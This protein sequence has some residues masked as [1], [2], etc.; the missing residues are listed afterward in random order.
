MH[1]SIF[2]KN[3][4]FFIYCSTPFKSMLKCTTFSQ[5]SL[6]NKICAMQNSVHVCLKHFVRLSH[7]VLP[8]H[9]DH[10]CKDLDWQ[11]LEAVLVCVCVC[12]LCEFACQHACLM[13][14][15]SGVVW[16]WALSP[17]EEAGASGALGRDSGGRPLNQ[18]LQPQ[19]MGVEVEAT[20]AVRTDHILREQSLWSPQLNMLSAASRPAE[21]TETNPETLRQMCVSRALSR[22][23]FYSAGVLGILVD[24]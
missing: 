23:V 24:I 21:W 10:R 22:G 3:I 20:A 18:P 9:G 12:V 11:L 13:K 5:G 17:G 2:F 8:L 14:T 7:T 6:R 4:F 15:T 19:E 1:L 16:S